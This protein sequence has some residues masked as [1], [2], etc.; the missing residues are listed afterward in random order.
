M[1][2]DKTNPKKRNPQ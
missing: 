1:N 2:F